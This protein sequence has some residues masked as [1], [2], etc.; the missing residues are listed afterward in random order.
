MGSAA[1]VQP[2]LLAP[3]ESRHFLRSRDALFQL[4]HA[5]IF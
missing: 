1:S 5:R 3:P 4:V 2:R